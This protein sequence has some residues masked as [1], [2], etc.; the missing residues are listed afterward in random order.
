MH[1]VA[2]NSE[3]TALFF[4]IRLDQSDCFE[5]GDPRP[6]RVTIG[7]LSGFTSSPIV[8]PRMFNNVGDEITRAYAFTVG[9][10][11]LMRL[12]DLAPDDG[13]G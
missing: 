11:T 5:E 7:N 4:G 8:S 1:R 10:S 2:E 6:V 3:A 9:T 13:P 12:H